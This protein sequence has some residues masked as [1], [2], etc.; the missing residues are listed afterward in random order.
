MGDVLH[1][2][3]RWHERHVDLEASL[4]PVVLVAAHERAHDVLAQLGTEVAHVRHELAQ[5]RLAG[6]ES[7][8]AKYLENGLRMQLGYNLQ[9]CGGDAADK[10]DGAERD[11]NADF[12]REPGAAEPDE[13]LHRPLAVAN[14]RQI[15]TARYAQRS[16]DVR[17]QI[18]LGHFGEGEVPECGAG[19][20]QSFVAV[21]V[22]VAAVVALRGESDQPV[23]TRTETRESCSPT[24]HENIKSGI[25]QQK[26]EAVVGLVDDPRLAGVEKAVLQKHCGRA[27]TRNAMH[28]QDVAVGGDNIVTFGGVAF[29]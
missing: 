17:R 3:A 13:R 26:P 11:I 22:G 23:D 25:V 20:A 16:L 27:R 15:L 6:K 4:V 7:V 18:V 14:V 10:S 8:G 19:V 9:E 29:L 21:A 12:R 5:L 28:R 2:R 1:R 24:H